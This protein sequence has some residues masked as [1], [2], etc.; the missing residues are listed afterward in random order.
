MI[1]APCRRRPIWAAQ[2][3]MERE[4]VKVETP[5]EAL[6]VADHGRRNNLEEV[7]AR[8]DEARR[9]EAGPVK[10]NPNKDKSAAKKV[11][12]CP[13]CGIERGLQG[14]WKHIAYCQGIVNA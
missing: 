9:E 5:A 2:K 1:T 7:Q 11:A 13:K 4:K 8:P 3:E 10:A 12:V 14:M 6:Q